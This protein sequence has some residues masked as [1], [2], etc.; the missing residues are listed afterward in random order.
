M[1]HLGLPHSNLASTSRIRPRTTL[2]L[3]RLTARHSIP[4][5]TDAIPN[6]A[7]YSTRRWGL[8]TRITLQENVKDAP[9][10]SAQIPASGGHPCPSCARKSGDARS[11]ANSRLCSA[12][13]R[14]GALRG[15][16]RLDAIPEAD[17]R[18]LYAI[19]IAPTSSGT[20]PFPS[21]PGCRRLLTPAARSTHI[22]IPALCDDRIVHFAK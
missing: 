17:H 7:S 1:R 5:T 3:F 8:S 13:G 2:D 15:T 19:A 9:L 14:P 22:D 18:R 6:G 21:T 16:A 10:R 4:R 12:R 20:T 11:T